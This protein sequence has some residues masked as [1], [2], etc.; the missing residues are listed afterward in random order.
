MICIYS[1]VHV[2]SLG[3]PKCFPSFEIFLKG[4]PCK[5]ATAAG[6]LNKII[7][8]EA[9]IFSVDI[10]CGIDIGQETKSGSTTLN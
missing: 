6:N 3:F 8:R 5:G 9:G 1:V 7:G 2:L 10:D 4:N